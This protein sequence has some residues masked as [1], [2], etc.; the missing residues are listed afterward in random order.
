MMFTLA[1]QGQ[2]TLTIADAVT[3]GL[4]G[5]FNVRIA[6]SDEKITENNFTR[7]NAGFLPEVHISGARSY[8]RESVNQE[9]ITGSVNENNN[10]SS[11]NWNAGV[12]LTWTVFDGMRMFRSYDKLGVLNEIG[13][14]DAQRAMEYAV[15]D[16]AAAYYD[17]VLHKSRVNALDTTLV[18]SQERVDLSR[19]RYEV[20]KAPRLEYLTA[21]VDYNTDYSGFLL[22]QD[23]LQKSKHDLNNLMG[24]SIEENFVVPL[25]IEPDTTLVLSELKERAMAANSDL[26]RAQLTGVVLDLESKEI[27]AEKIPS[28]DVN[29]GYGYNKLSSQ[30]GFLLSNRTSGVDY[31]LSLSWT[32]FDGL[33]VQREYENARIR[34]E[35]NEQRIEQLRLQILRDVENAFLDY[36]NNLQLVA[37]ERENLGVARESVTFAFD[38]YRLGKAT[39][40]ELREAQ[41]NAVNTFTRLF[42]ALHA[43]KIAELELRLLSGNIVQRLE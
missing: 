3:I 36:Q 13:A 25:V 12:D 39:F 8:T 18:L 41:V 2:D 31:G 22:Q 43:A 35:T 9:F 20:G 32:I 14:L 15:Y 27:Q 30:A 17:I 16:I 7:A 26:R 10:A 42:D 1:M 23:A 33:R 24:R 4:E 34:M 40:L 21:Q 38:R 19:T 37:L 6:Q 29:V 11:N 28:I 5:N